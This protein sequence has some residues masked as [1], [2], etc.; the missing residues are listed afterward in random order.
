MAVEQG[1]H[2]GAAGGARER[3]VGEH[4]HPAFARGR[5]LRLQPPQLP[6][7]HEPAG[8]AFAAYEVEHDRVHVRAQRERVVEQGPVIGEV[9]RAAQRAEHRGRG[10]LVATGIG[11]DAHGGGGLQP[12]DQ[13]VEQRRGGK[14]VGRG[15]AHARRDGGGYAQPFRQFPDGARTA[16]DRVGES[17]RR[18]DALD[19]QV[20]VAEHRVAARSQAAGAERGGGRREH[21]WVARRVD[22]RAVVERVWVTRP[23]H[24]EVSRRAAV[25]IDRAAVQRGEGARQL[26]RL[27]VVDHVAALHDRVGGERVDRAER[28]VEHLRAQRLLRPER[29][30]ER[31]AEASEERDA[32]RR[33]RVEHVRVGDVR[34]RRQ[35]AAEARAGRELR[36]L[37][38][39]RARPRTQLARA[40]GVRPGA[41]QRRAG[42]RRRSR[43]A[44]RPE[45]ER[46]RAGGAGGERLAAGEGGAVDAHASPLAT[47]SASARAATHVTAAPASAIRPAS[48]MARSLAPAPSASTA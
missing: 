31:R 14:P 48:R 43:R 33:L 29:R 28:A 21:P 7:M 2:A 36:T 42:G 10:Q 8:A 11:W 34:E 35:H 45:R 6:R 16:R 23:L 30:G 3:L 4:E 25:R 38:E 46:E 27:G 32:R 12:F 47:G 24:A 13:P 40:G 5:E 44:A 15:G 41:R 19:E 20:V 18:D 17:A 39:R 26:V 22:V 9:R 37:D 1:E